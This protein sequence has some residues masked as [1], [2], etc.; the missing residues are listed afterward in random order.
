MTATS[1]TYALPNLL[2]FARIAA[3][4]AVVGCL[5][6]PSAPLRA[7]ALAIF[8]AAA[9][10][11]W[12]DGYLARRMQAVSTLGRM[13]DPIADKLI[14]AAVLMMLVADATVPGVHVVAAVAILL[15]EI[16]ISGLREFFGGRGIVVP[17]TL[18]AKWK[19]T[20]QL[21]A[22]TVLIA[23]PIAGESAYMVWTAGI[24]LLWLAAAMTVWT[25]VQ[26]AGAMLSEHGEE[27]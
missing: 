5:I 23:W 10:T 22:I 2:T 27:S 24:L 20:A 25:G 8:M 15:R 7:A 18:L 6:V 16:F 9:A 11:D 14:V 26:Y 19:T 3:V 13:L 1:P 4:P 17:V 12:L 21:L